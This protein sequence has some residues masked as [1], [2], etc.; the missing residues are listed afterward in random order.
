MPATVAERLMVLGTLSEIGH[1]PTEPSPHHIAKLCRM[2]PPAQSAGQAS[3]D[4]F[5]PTLWFVIQPTEEHSLIRRGVFIAGPE[6]P[7]TNK[8]KYIIYFLDS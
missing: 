5:G 8:N 2:S 4:S 1:G 7:K 3:P 6:I